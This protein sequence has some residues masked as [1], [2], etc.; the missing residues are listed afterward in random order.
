MKE[1]IQ[2]IDCLTN[3]MVQIELKNGK[4]SSKRNIDQPVTGG[5][6]IGP[7]LTDLQINGF[8]SV[9][10]N[11]FPIT[12]N[13]FLKAIAALV[14]EGVTSFFPTV[15]TNSD[16]AIISLLENIDQCC[17]QHSSI[18]DFISG[19]H[20]EGPFLSPEAGARGAHDAKYIKAPDWDLFQKFQQASG[21]R[22]KLVTISPEWKGATSF[23][24][25]C[26]AEN[27]IVAIGHTIA[28]PLQ[29]RAAVD[30]GARLSTHLGNGAPLSLPRNN[31]FIFEQLAADQLVA[32]VIADGFHLPDSFLKITIQVKRD[33]AI[34]VSDSTKFAGMAPDVYETHIGGKV[35]LTKD[36]RLAT[37]ENKNIL[38]GSA[39]S[40]LD[41][42]FKLWK[43]D[44]TDLKTAWAMGSVFPKRLLGTS[45]E[46]METGDSL[47]LVLFRIKEEKIEVERVFKKGQDVLGAKVDRTG[48]RV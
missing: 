5:L 14:K 23:I 27:I 46:T 15:I 4:I 43:S 48:A 13:G 45:S 11:Q 7:G 18:A 6:Y 32:S 10:F 20:L 19:I 37:F 2:C 31:N 33:K 1:K 25:K 28:S 30:A 39:V 44:L 8:A 29:I 34:L 38:A 41:C 9:D 36:R 26:V 40:L 21:H 47:D 17:R 35:V 24:R 42:V 12:A 22:I 16:A 3:K